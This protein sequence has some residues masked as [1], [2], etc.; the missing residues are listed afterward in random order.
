MRRGQNDDDPLMRISRNNPNA[1]ATPKVSPAAVSQTHDSP[2][3]DR[4]VVANDDDKLDSSD[5]S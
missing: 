3:R 5:I 4:A 1:I 2:L